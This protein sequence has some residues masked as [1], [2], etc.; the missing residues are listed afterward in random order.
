MVMSFKTV[1]KHHY[2]KTNID[3]VKMYNI[4]IPIGIPSVTL[5]ESHSLPLPYTSQLSPGNY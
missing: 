4:S 5:L 3:I 1:V 2:Q